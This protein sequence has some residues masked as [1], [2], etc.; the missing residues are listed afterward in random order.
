MCVLVISSLC[1]PFVRDSSGL[2]DVRIRCD[3]HNHLIAEYQT[4]CINR[5]DRPRVHPNS[6]FRLLTYLFRIH[7]STER[8]VCWLPLFFPPAVDFQRFRI[9]RAVRHSYLRHRVTRVHNPQNHNHCA[10][11]QRR[12]AHSLYIVGCICSNKWLSNDFLSWIFIFG[13][14]D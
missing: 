12:V 10:L 7:R 4:R 1:Q 14:N 8:L 5:T 11:R 9:H 13:E 6:I 2:G 3:S